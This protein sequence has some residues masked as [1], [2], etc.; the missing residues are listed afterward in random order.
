MSD[1]EFIEDMQSGRYLT[2]LLDNQVFGIEIK[3]VTEIIGM[4]RI[5]KIPDVPDYLKGIINLRGRIIP[6]IDMRMKSGIDYIDYN[7]RT[8][9]IIINVQSFTLGL[10]VD[11]VSEVMTIEEDNIESPPFR[12]DNGDRYIKG[13]GKVKD[14]VI[15]ILDYNRLFD[16]NENF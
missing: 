5:T 12:D 4:Q 11:S 9:I 3:V 14:N 16:N 13:I 2:F 8:C 15:L 10:I 6:V 1:E 7:D